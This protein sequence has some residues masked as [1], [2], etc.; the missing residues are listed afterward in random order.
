MNNYDKQAY[1]AMRE[2]Q[3]YMQRRPSFTGR[4]T[5]GM[6]HK[7]NDMI[8]EKVHETITTA[9]KHMIKG[10]LTG[11][12]FISGN[13][14][15]NAD[16]YTR[17]ARV[18]D[19]ISV[20][21]S[22]A[23]AEGA[24]TGAGGFLLGLADFPLWLSIKMKMLFDMAAIYGHDVKDF[25]ERLYILHVFQLAFSGRAHRRN[26]FAT[27]ANWEEY[28]KSLPDYNDYDWRAFQQEYRDYIDLAKLLQLVPGIGAVVGAYVNHKM[29][30]KLGDTAMNA[31]RMR[32]FDDPANL[33]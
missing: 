23:A 9:F 24:I 18:K 6:Q 17:E 1:A 8:P 22:T 10:V 33:R 5:R 15:Q 7:I 11:A 16:L 2:W 29:T 12:E 25:K 3:K 20:Y 28:T 32:W 4:L 13:V 19:R 26:I 27:V 14:Y 30:D 21:R 31:Y